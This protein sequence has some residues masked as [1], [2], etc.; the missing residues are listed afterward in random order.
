MAV[1]LVLW[2][3]FS[4]HVLLVGTFFVNTLLSGDYDEE[5]AFGVYHLQGDSTSTTLTASTDTIPQLVESLIALCDS[6]MSRGKSTDTAGPNSRWMQTLWRQT[7]GLTLS[8]LELRFPRGWMESIAST[9]KSPNRPDMPLAQAKMLDLYDCATDRVDK[10]EQEVLLQ[11]CMA[12]APRSLPGLACLKRLAFHLE[13]EGAEALS[14]ALYSFSAGHESIWGS[15][16]W[17]G[18]AAPQT[19]PLEHGYDRAGVFSAALTAPALLDSEVG[20]FFVVESPSSTARPVDDNSL[21][22][23]IS[24]CPST[25]APLCFI[26]LSPPPLLLSLLL[27]LPHS[28]LPHHS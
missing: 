21:R 26:P 18:S 10:R 3:L 15:D 23:F 5:F 13:W 8:Q 4:R 24:A 12:A 7:W 17:F 19:G 6:K 28:S 25:R 20:P 2:L 16:S 11:L 14:H 22:L 27:S 1:F 9:E